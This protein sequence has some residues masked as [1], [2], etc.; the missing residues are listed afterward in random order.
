VGAGSYPRSLA[1]TLFTIPMAMY[2]VLDLANMARALEPYSLSNAMASARIVGGPARGHKQTR[3]HKSSSSSK[4]GSAE[5]AG[6]PNRRRR[7]RS[8]SCPITR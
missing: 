8:H 6:L 7:L 3:T 5:I 2:C 4:E 1:H